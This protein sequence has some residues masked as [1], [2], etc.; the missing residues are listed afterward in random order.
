MSMSM[1]KATL[2]DSISQ[3]TANALWAMANKMPKPAKQDGPRRDEF[4]AEVDSRVKARREA[5]RVLDANL[6]RLVSAAKG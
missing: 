5:R 6:I 1:R 4:W 3:D 2:S